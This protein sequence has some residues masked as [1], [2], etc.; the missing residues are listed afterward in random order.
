MRERMGML[1]SC[2]LDALQGKGEQHGDHHAADI[3][4]ARRSGTKRASTRVHRLGFGIPIR[5]VPVVT[6]IYKGFSITHRTYQIRGSGRWTVD[7]LVGRHSRL[8][9][10]SDAETFATEAEAIAGCCE[11]GRRI[12]DGKA[13]SCSLGDLRNE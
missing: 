2:W 13:G 10:F 9:A 11:F 4:R 7:V 3:V 5:R 8:R 12:I 1:L 6:T